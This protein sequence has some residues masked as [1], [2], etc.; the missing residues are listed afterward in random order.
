MGKWRDTEYGMRRI[1]A[2]SLALPAMLLAADGK[3]A[4]APLP[5]LVAQA[6]QRGVTN[7]RPYR[8]ESRIEARYQA[9]RAVI[10]RYEAQ[11]M[12]GSLTSG[13]LTDVLD[14]AKA[15]A[16]EI[17]AL[18]FV[19]EIERLQFEESQRDLSAILTSAAAMGIAI[20]ASPA[21]SKA[22][23]AAPAAPVAKPAVKPAAPA[24]KPAAK[25]AV[26]APKPA[27]PVAKPA[28]KPAPVV[29]APPTVEA[30]PVEVEAAAPVQAAEDAP[31]PAPAAA[32]DAPAVEPPAMAEPEASPVP[33]PAAEDPS[34]VPPPAIAPADGLPPE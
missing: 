5:D 13:P 31:I 21:S 4:P 7:E 26:A 3:D 2:A 20:D 15:I 22:P 19:T 12:Q 30:V 14:A 25:P 8:P 9:N 16:D 34:P 32:E 28:A 10:A 18:P 33:A 6:L 23:E 24:A 17:A 27:A 11:L 29:I 1:L